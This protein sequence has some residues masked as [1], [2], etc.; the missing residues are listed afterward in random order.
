MSGKVV[1]T[2]S[3]S[4]GEISDLLGGTLLNGAQRDISILTVVSTGDHQQPSSL[5]VAYEGVRVDGHEF[6]G[7]AFENGSIAAVVT[8]REKLGVRPGILVK[9][10]KRALSRLAAALAGEPSKDMRVIG[11]TGT[12]GTKTPGFE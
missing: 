4:L 11:I 7:Q 3:W 5:F 12:N 6:I 2:H 8:N 10:A 1:Q 9:D